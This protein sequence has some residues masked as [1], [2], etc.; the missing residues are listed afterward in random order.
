MRKLL[1]SSMSFPPE[2]INNVP[3]SYPRNSSGHLGYIQS[4]LNW[5]LADFSKINRITFDYINK[6]DL[7][8]KEIEVDPF[9]DNINDIE[10]VM[11][12]RKLSQIIAATDELEQMSNFADQMTIIG[13]WALAEQYISKIYK[14]FYSQL[15]QVPIKE[16][17]SFYRWPDYQR[18]FQA[19]NLDITTCYNFANAEEC[20]ILNNAMKHDV[21]VES[22]LLRFN[23]FKPFAQK[24]LDGIPIETQRYLNGVSDFLGSLIEK[25]NSIIENKI[26]I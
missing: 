26:L 14:E 5:K 21:N 6:R 2:E 20:R 25:S 11:I 13:L 24:K 16:V 12:S 22:K 8:L 3:N 19:L 10:N 17:K 15:K 1:Y 18:E 23:F 7:F 9:T 4:E